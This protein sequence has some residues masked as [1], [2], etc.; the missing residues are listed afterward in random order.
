MY[1]NTRS[2]PSNPILTNLKHLHVSFTENVNPFLPV[3]FGFINIG[4][5]KIELNII[6]E[7]ELIK[8]NNTIYCLANVI[9][10]YEKHD[11]CVISIYGDA[12]CNIDIPIL[13]VNAI[14]ILEAHVHFNCRINIPN[15]NSNKRLRHSFVEFLFKNEMLGVNIK[16]NN[17]RKGLDNGFEDCLE[18]MVCQVFDKEFEV[19]CNSKKD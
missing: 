6:D 3:I 16:S 10:E 5:G 9:N 17:L 4:V 13:G 19:F 14:K 7:I 2:C 8:P 15:I 1:K 18:Y 12:S 11:N